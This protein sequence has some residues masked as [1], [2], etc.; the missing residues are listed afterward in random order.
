MW[1]LPIAIGYCVEYNKIKYK[2]TLHNVMQVN[3]DETVIIQIF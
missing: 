1:G 2:V 3:D